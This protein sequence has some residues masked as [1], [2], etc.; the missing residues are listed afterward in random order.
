VPFQWVP[1]TAG[2]PT[3]DGNVVIVALEEGGDVNTRLTT[4]FEF[5]ISGKPTRTP[6]VVTTTETAEPAE[7]A[8]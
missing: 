1:N 3:W 4:D 2:A 8:A 5:G 7:P 6:G